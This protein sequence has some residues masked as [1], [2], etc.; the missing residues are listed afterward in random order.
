M[1][2]DVLDDAIGFLEQR[3][4]TPVIEGYE[5]TAPVTAQQTNE[6]FHRFERGVHHPRAP[7][8]SPFPTSAWVA[9]SS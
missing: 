8:P 4:R 2:L 9:L 3:I 1:G 5:H 6:C 7:M